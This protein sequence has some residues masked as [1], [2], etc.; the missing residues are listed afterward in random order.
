MPSDSSSSWTLPCGT[1]LRL[2]WNKIDVSTVLERPGKFVITEKTVSLE[3]FMECWDGEIIAGIYK[4]NSEIWRLI[5]L[6]YGF[7]HEAV[8]KQLY[9][10]AS[11][12]RNVERNGALIIMQRVS[13]DH[14]I[15]VNP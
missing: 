4:P 6:A 10:I 9:E 15:T 13:S 12:C 8:K 7:K 14:K 3:A 11:Y 5:S 2:D 1:R